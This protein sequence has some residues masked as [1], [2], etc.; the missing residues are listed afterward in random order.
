MGADS[1]PSARRPGLHAGSLGLFLE[2][3]ATLVRACIERASGS[4][5]VSLD[6]NIRPSLLLDREPVR[7]PFEWVL[8]QAHVLKLSDE[9]AAWLYPGFAGDDVV[10]QLLDCGPGL[11]AQTRGEAGSVM[12]SSE[13]SVQV[14]AAATVPVDTIG[15]GDVFM[16][17]LISQLLVRG[18]AEDLQGG[19]ALDA[20]DLAVVS[21]V[22]ARAAAITVGRPRAD[23]PWLD[24]LDEVAALA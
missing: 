4:T 21:G 16:G 10:E 5:L 15:A 6:P 13:A 18:L 17:T 9:D 11:V 2:P 12:A 8:P 24:E 23:P 3:G 1:H 22:A 14:P 19:R 7:R 20:E